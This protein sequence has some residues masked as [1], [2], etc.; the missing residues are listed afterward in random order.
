MSGTSF[1]KI[2]SGDL[3]SVAVVAQCLDNQWIPRELLTTMLAHG[4]SLRDSRVIG[5]RLRA[6]RHEYLRAL[7]NAQQVIVNRAF[8]LN[9]PVVYRDFQE[10]GPSRT[11]F[12][13][14]LGDS[15]IVPYL[16]QED[17]LVDEYD[18]TVQPEGASAWREV[19]GDTA[20]SCLRLSWDKAQNEDATRTKLQRPFRRQLLVL[21]DFEVASLERDFGLAPEE[22]RLLKARLIEVN[23]WAAGEESVTREQF[24]RKFVVADGT[25]PADG[26]YDRTKPFAAELKQLADLKYNIALPDAVGRFPMTPTGSLDRT[27]LQEVDRAMSSGRAVPADELVHMLRQQAFALAQRPLDVGL[28]GLE[29]NHVRQARGTEEWLRYKDSLLRLL[30][31]PERMPTAPEEFTARGQEVYDRYVA[32]AERLTGI[33]GRRREGAA[34]RWQPIIRLSVHTLGSVMSMVFDNEPHIEVAGNVAES[35]ATQASKAVVRFSVVGR[36][37]RRAGRQ[38]ETSFDLMQVEFQNTRDEWDDLA[39]R[40]QEAGFALR[41]A[42]GQAAQQATLNAPEDENGR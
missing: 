2:I 24:Y 16:Y 19:V 32:L 35:I 23:N 41:E 38:L 33:V 26:R 25:D 27:A 40:M 3:E 18:F 28:T 4:T 1:N 12:K 42:D 36:D 21:P 34:D 17:S 11:A 8:F 5:E 13:A 6:V 9:N 20:G 29:L 14:L 10:D 39:R 15:V 30:S 37:Q 22:A 31:E 7:L